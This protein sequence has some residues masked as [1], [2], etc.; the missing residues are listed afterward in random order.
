MPNAKTGTVTFDVAKAVAELKAGKIDFRVERAGIVHASVGKASFGPEKLVENLSVFFDTLIRL[1][2]AA[3][4]GTY[5]KG[6]AVSTTMGPGVR[7]DPTGIK[8]I[9]R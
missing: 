9:T 7:V 5:L 2:P 8:E 6:I 1:K 4:K 3:A